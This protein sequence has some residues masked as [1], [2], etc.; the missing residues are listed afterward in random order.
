MHLLNRFALILFCSIAFVVAPAATFAHFVSETCEE[1]AVAALSQFENVCANPGGNRAC[2]GYDDAEA[3]L[4]GESNPTDL[5]SQP[6]NQLDLKQVATIHTL[7]PDL[8]EDALGIA[9]LNV[10]ANLPLGLPGRD[11][12]YV[13]MGDVEVE[14]GVKPEDALNLPSE[15]LIINAITTASLFNKPTIAGQ[16]IGQVVAGTVL[17]ADG[18]SPDRQWLRVYFEYDREY[19]AR[20]DAWINKSVIDDAVEIS[21]LPVIT[22]DS[23]TPM[24]AFYL[25]NSLAQTNCYEQV[26]PLLFLQGPQ[27]IETDITVNEVDVRISSSIIVRILPPGNLMQVIVLSGIA[28]LNPDSPNPLIIPAGYLTEI[29]LIEDL[30][31][32]IDGQANDSR[33]ADGAN[34]STPRLLTQEELLGLGG[35][36]SLPSGILNY[37]LVLPTITCPSGVGQAV[38]RVI[39][40]DDSLIQHTSQL[41]ASGGLP[42]SI[43]QG[44]SLS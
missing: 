22:D 15:P 34:W 19:S 44:I 27:S 13:L 3:L 30:N 32:G 42:E 6:G 20:A 21:G 31:L 28:T 43:C 41:C 38:C 24:Q 18:V 36:E 9:T 5:F 35:L 33:P 37:R 10:Q 2:Y 7:A 25:R 26:S 29:L 8:G 16:A 39:Y 23:R 12:V 1:L 11:A 40:S 17:V 4:V 14:N